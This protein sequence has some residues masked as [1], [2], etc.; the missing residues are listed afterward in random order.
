MKG[1]AFWMVA[2]DMKSLLMKLGNQDNL[3]KDSKGSIASNCKLL[4]AQ[5]SFA[6]SLVKKSFNE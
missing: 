5:L 2:N 4:C 3:A 6:S 1:N